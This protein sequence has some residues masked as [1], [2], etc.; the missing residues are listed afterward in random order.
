MLAHAQSEMPNEC[1]GILS[2][3]IAAGNAHVLRG[4][5]L[6][7]DLVSPTEYHSKPESL[8]A[9]A[10]EM[11][12]LGHTLLVVYHSHPTSDPIPSRKDLERNNYPDAIH[13]IISL[14][15]G[16]PLARAWWLTNTDYR[17]ATWTIIPD[18]G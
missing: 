18:E 10:R 13:I 11:R 17:E 16:T 7:N 4:Y 2:G 8:F 14:K 15:S 9:V 3:R 12:L 1:V 6:V 5:S